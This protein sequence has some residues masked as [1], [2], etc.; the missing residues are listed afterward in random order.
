MMQTTRTSFHARAIHHAA[1]A[2]V[3]F[4]GIAS[5]AGVAS[6]QTSVSLVGGRLTI[7]TNNAEQNVKVEMKEAPG[8]ARLFGFQ[9]VLDG[10][11]YAGVTGVTIN[12][13]AARDRV[14]FDIETRVSVD[15]RVNS[16][17]GELESKTQVK[18]LPAAVPVVAGIAYTSLPGALKLVN[19]EVDNEAANARVSIDTGN[20]TEVNAKVLSDDP[21]N[22]LNV[23]F[24]ARGAKTTVE[25][26]S[27]ASVLDV[28]LSGAHAT[29]GSEVKHV[30]GQLRPATV[31]VSNNVTLSSGSDKLESKVAAPGSSVTI[32]GAARGG[33][34]D[35]LALFEIEGASV[36]NG[37]SLEGGAGNDLLSNQ[38]K[39][40]FQLSQTVGARIL[41]GPG[42]DLLIL[43][44]DTAIRG[45]GLPNDV[46]N[47]ID[48]GEGF[49]LYNAFGLIRNCEG[50]L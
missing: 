42:D 35:D 40:V 8:V 41:A 39:G 29:P 20:A 43:T 21:S 37:L 25:L 33:D 31:R 5:F 28:S 3:S 13:G 6:A 49:D 36:V 12:T 10:T 26:A 18:V 46:Q 4:A 30:I 17:A 11:A 38:T 23:A 44:T 45:T 47:V 19:V 22:S 27:A 14:E 32:V 50:R 34:G 9:G 48:G 24:N 2:L 15:L 1:I 7:T 16:G